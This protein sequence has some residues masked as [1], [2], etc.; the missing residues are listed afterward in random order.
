[1]A[2]T[3]TGRKIPAITAMES[4]AHQPPE[5]GTPHG[6]AGSPPGPARAGTQSPLSATPAQEIPALT[7]C[8]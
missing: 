1:M 4:L 3:S 8:P 2:F 7:A 5:D 6:L